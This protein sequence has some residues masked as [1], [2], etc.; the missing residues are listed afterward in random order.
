MFESP[1][2]VSKKENGYEIIGYDN[3]NVYDTGDQDGD[4]SKVNC[5]YCQNPMG[6]IT[7]KEQRGKEI[8]FI[9][10]DSVKELDKPDLSD[11]ELE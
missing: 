4:K 7:N 8:I 11:D 6:Y 9:N 5:L 3:A 10:A 1:E 2:G